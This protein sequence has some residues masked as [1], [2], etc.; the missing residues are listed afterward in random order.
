[1]LVF[2]TNSNQNTVD[3]EPSF[4]KLDDLD[5]DEPQDVDVKQEKEKIMNIEGSSTDMSS[6]AVLVKVGEERVASSVHLRRC[7]TVKCFV[8]LVSQCFSDIVAGQVARNISQCNIPCNGQNR[9]ETS[10]KS[11]CRK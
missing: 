1:M 4:K 6:F 5:S 8:Q 9:C 11:R 10:C 2:S 7:Y 3:R